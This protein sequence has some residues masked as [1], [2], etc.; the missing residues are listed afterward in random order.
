MSEQ[1]DPVDL[2]HLNDAVAELVTRPAIHRVVDTLKQQLQH[3]SEPFVW[4]TIDL[5]SIATPLP[6]GIKS[7]WI[8]VLR[9]DVSS[10]CHYHP[11]SIQH[12]V[13]IEGEG[14]SKVGTVAGE[15]KKFGEPNGSPAETWYVIPRGVTHEFF[16]QG[17]DVVVVSFHTCSPDEL[18]EISCD[19]GATRTYE[20]SS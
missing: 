15:M 14:T 10:G 18:E 11:N 16:P 8:F 17:K 9:K 19:S 5:E 7:G 1:T 6:A 12:M 2:Q 20:A 3:T 13:M 4:S